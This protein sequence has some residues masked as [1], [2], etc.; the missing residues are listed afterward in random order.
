MHV[1]IHTHCIGTNATACEK[2]EMEWN[3]RRHC[4][5][6]CMQFYQNSKWVSVCVCKKKV[7]HGI[8]HER[9]KKKSRP[10]EYRFVHLAIKDVFAIDRLTLIFINISGEYSLCSLSPQQHCSVFAFSVGWHRVSKVKQVKPLSCCVWAKHWSSRK[11]HLYWCFGGIGLFVYLCVCV[12][13]DYVF[14][15]EWSMIGYYFATDNR[16]VH[17]ICVCACASQSN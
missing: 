1:R 14:H 6:D 5:C 13:S 2:A 8:A 4:I 11:N 15:M 10:T 3:V 12:C 17:F 16:T 7:Q 9:R